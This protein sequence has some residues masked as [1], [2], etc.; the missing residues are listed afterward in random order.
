MAGGGVGDGGAS[1]KADM[2]VLTQLK[3]QHTQCEP[4]P[5]RNEIVGSLVEIRGLPCCLLI[6]EQ[7]EHTVLAHLVTGH[8]ACC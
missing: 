8:L 6:T 4:C 3:E 5:D 7:S 2:I 1:H